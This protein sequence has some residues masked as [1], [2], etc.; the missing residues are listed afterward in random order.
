M[1]KQIRAARA[2]ARAVRAESGEN[3]VEIGEFELTALKNDKKRL[4]FLEKEA[5]EIVVNDEG[6]N[7]CQMWT[8]KGVVTYRAADTVRNAIDNAILKIKEE[9]M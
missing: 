2:W 6:L 3:T 9:I 4:D 7:E 5:I 8:P 1:N